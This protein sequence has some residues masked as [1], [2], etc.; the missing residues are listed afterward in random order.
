MVQVHSNV[1][2]Q[3][4]HLKGKAAKLKRQTKLS[5][6]TMSEELTKLCVVDDSFW[7][8]LDA[9]RDIVPLRRED[10]ES[11]LIG[12][13]VLSSSR[14]EDLRDHRIFDIDFW[15]LVAVIR[16]SSE[17]LVGHLV[18]EGEPGTLN[19]FPM[20]GGV[21]VVEYGSCKNP[22]SK[23]PVP[24]SLCFWQ[25]DEPR[26]VLKASLVFRPISR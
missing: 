24:P 19:L 9:N 3:T 6:A 17:G 15:E 5:W 11:Q 14:L 2:I 1:V 18:G 16:E 4:R 25:W 7:A 22:F 13:Q 23:G 26:V 20:F 21:A 12:D 10:L 8:A